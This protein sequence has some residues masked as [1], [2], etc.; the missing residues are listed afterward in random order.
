MNT[1]RRRT[2]F[3]FIVIV[4]MFFLFSFSLIRKDKDS[5]NTNENTTITNID[6]T[7]TESTNDIKKNTYDIVEKFV[8]SYHLIS[9]EN[10]IN[11]LDSIKDTLVEPLYLDLL[12]T[13][14]T[15]DTMPKNGYVYRNINNITIVDFKE[16]EDKSVM[17]TA[18]AWSD[19][20]DENGN[21]TDTNIMTKYKILLVNQS[22][23]WKIGQISLENI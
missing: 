3:L 22:G 20:T 18:N 16:L 19:W 4:I 12:E 2:L 7:T 9:E 5:I 11:R 17:W 1:D 21:L 8:K 6:K 10:N 23:N 13:I 15:E 14:K